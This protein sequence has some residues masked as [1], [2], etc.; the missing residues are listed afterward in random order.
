MDLDQ[1]AA[2]LC[3]AHSKD[4]LAQMARQGGWRGD[5]ARTAKSD[6]AREVAR[7]RQNT[8][9]Q[10]AVTEEDFAAIINVPHYSRAELLAAAASVGIAPTASDASSKAGLARMLALNAHREKRTAIIQH[11]TNAQRQSEGEA[12]GQSRAVAGN[13]AN[14]EPNNRTASDDTATDEGQGEG[15]AAQGQGQ[16]ERSGAS[17]EDNDAGEAKDGGEEQPKGKPMQSRFAGTCAKCGAGF[18]KGSAIT[19]DKN[20]K[21]TYHAPKCPTPQQGQDGNDAR[22]QQQPKLDAAQDQMRAAIKALGFV[23]VPQAYEISE[24]VT[25]KVAEAAQNAAKQAAEA[26]AKAQ[27]PRA[28]TVE[29]KLPDGT[30]RDMG[31]QHKQFG[32]LAKVVGAGCHAWVAGPAGS[33][34][35]TAAAAV[36]EALG[37]SF[38]F[39]GALDTEYKVCGF[40]DAHGRIVSTAF[41]KAYTEGGLHLFDECDASLA[42]A[43]LAINAA[44]A[45]GHAAF[46]DGTAKKHDNFRCIAAANTWGTGATFDYVGRSKLDAAFLDRF[47]R[48]SW[49]YDEE[50]ER[51]TSGNLD[52][53][54]YVQKARK[55]AAAKGVRVVISPRATYHGARLLAAGL[56]KE[57]VIT[58]TMRNGMRPEDWTTIKGGM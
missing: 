12:G 20:T 26:I 16:G 14:V 25:A 38:S 35:T 46:P 6:I 58:L 17:G 7:Q 5:D 3:T 52:W 2:E 24:E 57:E 55:A 54:A 49:E 28:T 18:P 43:L 4:Q 56:P 37:L 36:A 40:V 50:L 41:R 11:L 45:N 15:R 13:V 22:Q 23:D 53:C 10:S 31:R 42:P 19:Y 39:D 27:Q 29:I 8:P 9:P 34:K 51:D 21:K 30:A 32:T 1:A 48:L 44:L 33:G 47:V